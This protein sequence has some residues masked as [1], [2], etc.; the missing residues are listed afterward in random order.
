MA[1]VGQ[2]PFTRS[3]FGHTEKWREIIVEPEDGEQHPTLPFLHAGDHFTAADKSVW[4]VVTAEQVESADTSPDSA[5]SYRYEW[6]Y[7]CKEASPIVQD[8]STAGIWSER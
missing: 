7:L 8:P 1:M 6:R 2:Y 3:E 5:A 4:A